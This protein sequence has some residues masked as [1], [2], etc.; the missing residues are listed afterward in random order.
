M[1]HFSRGRALLEAWIGCSRAQRFS[2][3]GAEPRRER[4]VRAHQEAVEAARGLVAGVQRQYQVNKP[5]P[6]LLA[7]SGGYIDS[8]HFVSACLLQGSSILTQMTDDRR[9]SQQTGMR[10]SNRASRPSERARERPRR[11]WRQSQHHSHTRPRSSSNM[12][13][14]RP[15]RMQH[16]I[17]R[18]SRAP[19]RPA[20][21]DFR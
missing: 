17:T 7:R 20:K 16:E 13:S 4:A 11:R 10:E 2:A 15:R 6:S 3:L 8:R 9:R 5:P 19:S 21:R 18:F 14:P 1:H 12:T